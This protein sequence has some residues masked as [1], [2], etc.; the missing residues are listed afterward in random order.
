MN[1]III[2]NNNNTIH[3]KIEDMDNEEEIIGLLMNVLIFYMKEL[4]LDKESFL[5]IMEA[6]W[7]E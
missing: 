2:E 3:T 6:Y 1:K 5:D 7:D 4:E